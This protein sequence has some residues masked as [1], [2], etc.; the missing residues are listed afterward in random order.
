MAAPLRGTRGAAVSP[1][2]WGRPGCL[3][4]AAGGRR[5]VLSHGPRACKFLFSWEGSCRGGGGGAVRAQLLSV[6]VLRVESSC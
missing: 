6:Q 3:A 5:A 1:R 2:G 4:G